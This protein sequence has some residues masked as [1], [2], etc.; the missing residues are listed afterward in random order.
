MKKIVV[1]TGASGFFGYHMCKNLLEKGYTVRGIDIEPFEY[2]DIKGEV[3]FFKGDVRDKSLADKITQDCFAVIHAA[4]ALPLRSKEEIEDVNFNGTKYYLEAAK[5]NGV[6]RFVFISSTAVY[7]IPDYPDVTEEEVKEG[8]GP[9]GETK[10]RAENLCLEYKEDMIVSILRPKSFAGPYRLGVFEVLC[11]WVYSKKNIPIIG[12]GNNAYQLLHIDDLMDVCIMM[13]E[14]D[15]EVVSDVYNVASSE[16][17]TMKGDLQALLDYAGFG[18]KVIP[19][20]SSIIIP[21][22]KVFD[23]LGISP[24]YGW[25]Y[26]TADHDHTVSIDKIVKKTGWKPKYSTAQVWID[27][28][29]WYEKNADNIQ[30]TGTTHR[31]KW[32]QGI[33]GIA[34]MFF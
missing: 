7:G 28:Y 20:P 19:F 5:K 29:K 32:K 27:T 21:P 1:V 12:S 11:D 34:K 2:E 8:V 16:Y 9:Y 14:N 33:V 30:A 13:L 10:V 31:V 23:R 18:K 26:E 24:L 17:T 15:E 3:E 25:V 6:E 4:A 22:L